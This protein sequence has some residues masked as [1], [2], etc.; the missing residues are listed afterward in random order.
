MG[1]FCGY[2]QKKKT[3][4]DENLKIQHI[5]CKIMH[6]HMFASTKILYINRNVDTVGKMLCV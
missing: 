2:K 1:Q 4:T 3:S 5:I 6:M